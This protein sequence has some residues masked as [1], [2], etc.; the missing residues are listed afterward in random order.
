ML[1]TALILAQASPIGGAA[2]VRVWLAIIG[3]FVGLIS[4]LFGVFK[5][6]MTLKI[7]P[8]EERIGKVEKE[9][10]SL[11]DDLLK[12]VI[13]I[14]EDNASHRLEQQ[15]QHGEL[16]LLLSEG[17]VKKDEMERRVSDLNEKV[18]E[19]RAAV[20]ARTNTGGTAYSSG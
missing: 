13:Q 8:L 1:A 10:K 3:L 14:A 2:E 11:Q 18:I 20:N 15:K 19:L 4:G 17:Y 9:V 16:R 6:I 12:Q 7:S 5:Y